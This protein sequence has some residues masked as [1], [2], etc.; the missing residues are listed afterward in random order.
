MSLSWNRFRR[1]FML[2]CS[3]KKYQV[4]EVTTMTASW[5]VKVVEGSCKGRREE[6]VPEQSSKARPP[7]KHQLK[8]PHWCDEGLSMEIREENFMACYEKCSSMVLRFP[9]KESSTND[10]M[11]FWIIFCFTFPPPPRIVTL[12]CTNS[13]ILSWQKNIDPYPL[14]VIWTTPY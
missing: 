10:V 3:L 7:L 4:A 13:L 12:L 14:I 8:R 9:S 1:N 6:N 5:L 2:K 11:Q